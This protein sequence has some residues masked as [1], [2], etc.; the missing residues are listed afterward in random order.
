MIPLIAIGLGGLVWY[1]Q[2][3]A[4]G[5][6]LDSG[7]SPAL[8]REVLEL[9]KRDLTVA[10][11]EALTEEFGRAHYHRAQELFAARLRRLNAGGSSVATRGAPDIEGELAGETNP[12]VLRRVAEVLGS[13]GHHAAAA[14]AQ[15]RAAEL[16]ALA[17]PTGLDELL[18][19]AGRAAASAGVGAD[20]AEG[21]DPEEF[22][23]GEASEEPDANLE[24]AADE[25]DDRQAVEAAMDAAERAAT[26]RVGSTDTSGAGHDELQ[27]AEAIAPAET[28]EAQVSPSPSPMSE[29]PQVVETEGVEISNSTVTPAAPRKRKRR[30][31]SATELGGR[32]GV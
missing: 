1:A 9:L 21:D 30:R 7:M 31:R 10:Q 2:R 12:A 19:A 23:G 8:R 26:G 5:P 25:P 17:P 29:T 16:E 4:A 6:E 22:D 13:M 15:A 20:P 32:D 28:S 11:L 24:T 18:Q 27:R 3:A 14:R